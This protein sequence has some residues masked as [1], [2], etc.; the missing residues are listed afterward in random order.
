VPLDFAAQKLV[1]RNDWRYV[2]F[3]ALR[4][5]QL[6]VRMGIGSLEIAQLSILHSAVRR[7]P[8]YSSD[9][10]AADGTPCHFPFVSF[11]P[12]GR[13][14]V[15]TECAPVT[16]AFA[17]RNNGT[18]LLWCSTRPSLMRFDAEELV[19][20][21]RVGGWYGW[22][23]A[24][25]DRLRAGDGDGRGHCSCDHASL[26]EPARGRVGT[27]PFD[28]RRRGVVDGGSE[29]E[30]MPGHCVEGHNIGL[31]ENVDVGECKRLCDAKPSILGL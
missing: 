30:R 10:H 9:R 6:D 31:F 29:Y 21:C 11:W 19:G 24:S 17:Q 16:K 14:A 26:P 18:V 1:I 8:G 25:T 15:H 12:D 5:G 4:L 27:M 22:Q 28:V 13:R 23:Y 7:Y 20:G 3:K 2:K